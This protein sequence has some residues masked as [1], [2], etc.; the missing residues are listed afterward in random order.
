[1][2]QLLDCL[3]RLLGKREFGTQR[4]RCPKKALPLYQDSPLFKPQGSQHDSRIN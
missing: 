3:A 4:I 2:I 1:M